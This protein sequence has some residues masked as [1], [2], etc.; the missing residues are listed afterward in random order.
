[1][2][3]YI[4]FLIFGSIFSYGQDCISK[5]LISTDLRKGI[6]GVHIHI[7][8]LTRE[9]TIS[10]EDGAF[11][12]CSTALDSLV[13]ISH[14]GYKK[15]ELRL[16]DIES[17]TI[18]LRPNTII[19]EEIRISAESGESIME[20]VI[21]SL[22]VNH[23][24]EPILYKS[25]V[26]VVEYES[27]KS[28]IHVFSEYLINV[29]INEKSKHRYKLLKTRAMPVSGAGRKYFKDMR[30]MK[31]IS[32]AS[33]HIFFGLSDYLK[34]R[35]LKNFDISTLET[36]VDSA[37]KEIKL[38]SLK[39]DLTVTLLIEKQTYAIT[40]ILEKYGKNDDSEVVFKKVGSKWILD[41]ST[42]N[43]PIDYLFDRYLGK[44]RE[45]YTMRTSKTIF[46]INNYEEATP[47]YKSY[48][49]I[50]AEP[51]KY[52]IGDWTDEFWEKN[53]FIPIPKWMEEKIAESSLTHAK[54]P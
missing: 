31:G 46:N 41:Y 36:P 21:D 33:R 37:L 27:D 38:V 48:I 8:S 25:F 26:R 28:D 43:H 42:R 17:D 16:S 39:E 50:V 34:K 5:V 7:A 32:G 14:V 29:E 12:L 18:E 10:N 44:N 40:K 51:I 15:I 19:L 47:D 1:M 23:F 49:N 6:S 35:K 3:L 22:F 54:N 53:T 11:V 30:I 4:F 20:S 52:H 13:S 24:V 2:R 45:V 9:G